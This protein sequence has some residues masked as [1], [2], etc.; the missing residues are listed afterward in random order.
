MSR[1]ESDGTRRSR[2]LELLASAALLADPGDRAALATIAAEFTPRERAG[3]RSTEPAGRVQVYPAATMG[4]V[5]DVASCLDWA[6]QHTAAD[7]PHPLAGAYLDPATAR[8]YAPLLPRGLR[9]YQRSAHVRIK[10]LGAAYAIAN[11]KDQR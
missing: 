10:D 8:L 9:F 2:L 4:V 6:E 1:P 11:G 3:G 5:E 7:R